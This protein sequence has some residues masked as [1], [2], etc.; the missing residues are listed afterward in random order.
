MTE[1]DP[2]IEVMYGN[3]K[4]KPSYGNKGGFTPWSKA[5]KTLQSSNLVGRELKIRP[6]VIYTKIQVQT[7]YVEMMWWLK[8]YRFGGFFLDPYIVSRASKESTNFVKQILP[9]EFNS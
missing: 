1:R 5:K 2:T 8:W 3:V 6:K 9:L 7:V 4:V